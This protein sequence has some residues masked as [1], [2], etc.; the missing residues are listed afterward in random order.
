[1]AP[2]PW[3]SRFLAPRGNQDGEALRRVVKGKAVLV[4]GASF[5]IGEALA[6]RLGAAGARVLLAARSQ[7]ELEAVG[8]RITSAGGEAFAYP[9]DLA[10]AEQVEALAARIGEEHGAVDVVVHNA[11]KSIRRSL[12]RSLDRPHDFERCM[13][14]NYLGPV[15]L[16]LALLPAMLARGAGHIVSVSSVGV[17]LPPG[18]HWAAYSASKSAFD[19]W[20]G[21]AAPEL[22]QGGIACTRVY[23]GLVHTRMSA[24][25][26]AYA[27]MP[28]QT[29]DQAASVLCRALIARPRTISPWWLEPLHWLSAPLEGLLEW[30]Q[31]RFLPPDP[32]LRDRAHP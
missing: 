15:R 30:A 14:V 8:Q 13:A 32:G 10:R 18:A 22:R 29:A 7:A 20:L 6:V 5:G 4:T 25:T 19:I 11:G 17:R 3:L 26:A 16:Q 1:M 24:P 9:A 2:H 28:G 27:S 21:S 23:L 31:Y 12:Y